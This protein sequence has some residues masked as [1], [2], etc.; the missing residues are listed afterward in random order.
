MAWEEDTP[1]FLRAHIIT[2]IT[3]CKARWFDATT[4][5]LNFSLVA[6]LGE[7]NLCQQWF[8]EDDQSTINCSGLQG[9]QNLAI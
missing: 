1:Y 8:N 2:H 6:L 4:L 3:P 7:S 5:Y 9:R